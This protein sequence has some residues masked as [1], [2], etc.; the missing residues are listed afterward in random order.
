MHYPNMTGVFKGLGIASAYCFPIS[1]NCFIWAVCHHIFSIRHISSN[2]RVIFAI[3]VYLMS[4]D[5][6]SIHMQLFIVLAELVSSL[7][8]L[9]GNV[10]VH[11]SIPFC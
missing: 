5:M 4:Y 8:I 11:L 9:I 6:I 7:T 10:L 2:H 1:V 3:H